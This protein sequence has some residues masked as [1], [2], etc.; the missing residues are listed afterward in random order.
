[1]KAFEIMV[2]FSLSTSSFQLKVFLSIVLFE[3]LVP[4]VE[5]SPVNQVED[6]KENW[7]KKRMKELIVN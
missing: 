7:K 4:D 6:E 3:E 2:V 5:I 1:M